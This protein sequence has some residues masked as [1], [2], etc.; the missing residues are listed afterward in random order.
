VKTRIR[1]IIERAVGYAMLVGALVVFSYFYTNVNRTQKTSIEDLKKN[2][3]ELKNTI[4]KAEADFV[5]RK[6]Q[7]ARINQQLETRQ[8]EVREKFEALLDKEINYPRLI[9]QVQRKAKALNI[10]IL[11]SKYEPPAR[12]Q[13]APATYLEFKFSMN[14]RGGYEKMKQFLWEMENAMGRFVKIG[15]MVVKPPI[16]DSTG[17]MNLTLTFSTYFLP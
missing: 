8:K 14:V 3:R 13:G 10:E 4:I 1:S 5:E 12:V 9:E 2:L 6:K 17:N 7:V 15:Q 11:N 16:C